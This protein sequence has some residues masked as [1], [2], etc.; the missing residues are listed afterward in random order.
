MPDWGPP[1][2][3]FSDLIDQE[4]YNKQRKTLLERYREDVEKSTRFMDAQM[5]YHVMKD[6]KSW[7]ATEAT[8]ALSKGDIDV[9]A[10]FSG[11]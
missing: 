3:D 8:E 1:I 5:D 11:L 4:E 2:L 9:G 10:F 6:Y 7:A